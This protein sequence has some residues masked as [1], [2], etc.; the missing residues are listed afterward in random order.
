MCERRSST[1]QPGWSMTSVVKSVIRPNV[2]SLDTRQH[3]LCDR[4]RDVLHEL[5]LWTKE[6]EA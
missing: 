2:F 5:S 4:C 6:V 1:A 3:V